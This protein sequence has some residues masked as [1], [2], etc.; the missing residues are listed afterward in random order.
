MLFSKTGT[1]SEYSYRLASVDGSKSY[2]DLGM[3]CMGLMTAQSVGN[4]K[5]NT[6]QPAH[7]IVCVMRVTRQYPKSTKKSGLTS[8]HARDFFTVDRLE[9]LY[10]L[11]RKYIATHTIISGQQ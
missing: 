10:Y 5:L 4:V 7:G 1:P 2:I 8:T 6:N 9:K 3:Y 11:T